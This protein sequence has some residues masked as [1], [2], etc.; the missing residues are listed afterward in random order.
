M[1][2]GDAQDASAGLCQVPILFASGMTFLSKIV[3]FSSRR[4]ELW[5]CKRSWGRN[6]EALRPPSRGDRRPQSKK[7]QFRGRRLLENCWV[8]GGGSEG[9]AAPTCRGS[10]L[11]RNLAIVSF[12]PPPLQ[13]T[14]GKTRLRE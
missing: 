12:I 5:G 11:G 3:L 9:R 8:F 4:K 2:T 13:G 7:F 14:S 10:E 1:V 6:T